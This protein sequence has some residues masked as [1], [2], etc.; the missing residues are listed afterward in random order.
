M[1]QDSLLVNIRQEF[2]ALFE[3]FHFAEVTS[4]I[5]NYTFLYCAVSP[6]L[7]MRIISEQ[8]I[9]VSFSQLGVQAL[10]WEENY[11]PDA[12]IDWILLEAFLQG[13][14]CDWH[15][16][17]RATL[18]SLKMIAVA[19]RRNFPVIERMFRNFNSWIGEFRIYQS[20]EVERL[21]QQIASG[22]FPV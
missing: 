8:G 14:Q 4:C 3:E 17:P 11:V 9:S 10:P 19:L 16:A 15:L 20:H 18:D 7:Q 1:N 13:T 21:K 2:S 6:S 12:W 5:R 22:Q